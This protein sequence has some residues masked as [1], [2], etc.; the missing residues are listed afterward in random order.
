MLFGEEPGLTNYIHLLDG[1]C[2]QAVPAN[3]VF[4]RVP[5]FYRLYCTASPEYSICALL[6]GFNAVLYS[7][8]PRQ[9][10]IVNDGYII[11]ASKSRD[12]KAPPVFPVT[13]A[14][15]HTISNRR[16][17]FHW[18]IILIAPHPGVVQ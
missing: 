17:I 15:N 3:F 7:A 5:T 4:G 2:M 8:R 16:E 10:V 9:D 12:R 13:V 1:I 18:L 14:A 11:R 6:N